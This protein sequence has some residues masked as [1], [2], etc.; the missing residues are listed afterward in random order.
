MG[1]MKSLKQIDSEWFEK[2]LQYDIMFLA[3]LLILI[4]KMR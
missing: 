3:E 1:N 2:S 4:E